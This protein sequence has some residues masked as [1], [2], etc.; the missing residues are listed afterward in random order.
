MTGPVSKGMCTFC[1][2]PVAKSAMAK[3]LSTC[4]PRLARLAELPVGKAKIRHT[5]L[6]HLR[7][8]GAHLGEYWMHV[9]IPADAS[10][11]RLDSFLRRVWLECCGHLSAFT[12]GAEHHMVMPEPGYGEKGMAVKLGAVFTPGVV[13]LH[14]YDFGTTTELTVKYIVEREA[15]YRGHDVRVM[16]RNE[17]PVYPCGVCGAPAVWVCTQCI[18]EGAGWLCDEHAP[19]HACGEDML[20]PVTNSPRVGMCGYTGQLP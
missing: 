14:R 17:P 11:K 16:A 4:E 3:H 10:L 20:L 19:E 12:I 15:D 9:E 13:A 6:L 2:K 18:W 1:K 5:R 7:V 8:E